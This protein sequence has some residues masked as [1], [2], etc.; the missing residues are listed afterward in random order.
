M[1]K[2]FYTISIT[3][4]AV[5]ALSAFMASSAFAANPEWLID[6]AAVAAGTSTE[7]KGDLVFTD[8]G[9]PGQPA[10]LCEMIFDGTI[11]PGGVD[12]TTEILNL[13]GVKVTSILGSG[14]VLLC[15]P[16]KTCAGEIEVYPLG[17]PW[18]TQLELSG[19]NVIDL[20]SA[21]T[22]G[23][24]VACTVLGIKVT[25]E[26]TQTELSGTVENMLEE[27]PA[28]V[29]QN[30]A[31]IGEGDCTVGGVKEYD[32]EGFLLI[33]ALEGLSLTVSGDEVTE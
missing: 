22:I 11:G 6:G 20:M 3:A 25:D 5:F 26:C 12:E 24:E 17:L 19:A 33:T 4:F 16:V 7:S 10:W 28:D 13:A 8:L 29:L 31:A 27:T 14:T 32:V 2:K 18:K 15:P 9:A 21:T 1:M 23:Y 30:F